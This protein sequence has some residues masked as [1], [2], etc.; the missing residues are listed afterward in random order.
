MSGTS[1]DGVDAVLVRITGHG[2]LTKVEQLAFV[3]PP[4]TQEVR[5]RILQMAGGQF[6]G[7]KEACLFNAFMGELFAMLVL[8]SAKRP[9]F[10]RRI[11]I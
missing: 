11:S 6:G 8:C 4:Y 10:R 7:T 5:E 3:S 9:A 2:V 1:A